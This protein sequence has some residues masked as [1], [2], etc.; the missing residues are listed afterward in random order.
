LELPIEVSETKPKRDNPA[1]SHIDSALSASRRTIPDT[2]PEPTQQRQVSASITTSE[3][4]LPQSIQSEQH[5]HSAQ[6]PSSFTQ[7]TPTQQ[8]SFLTK[9]QSLQSS[10]TS[11]LPSFLMD[12]PLAASFSTTQLPVASM[13]AQTQN[14]EAFDELERKYKASEATIKQLQSRIDEY[15]SF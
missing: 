15:A 9:Q 7:N 8:P 5:Q 1:K 4:L 13:N 6:M 2:L 12:K 3:Q 14:N 11:A 10:T